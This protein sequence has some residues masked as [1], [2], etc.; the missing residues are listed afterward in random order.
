MMYSMTIFGN[1]DF[2][3]TGWMVENTPF[4]NHALLRKSVK[5]TQ[6]LLIS[7]MYSLLFHQKSSPPLEGPTEL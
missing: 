7:C 6:V 1:F 5:S 4:Q 2:F 3:P